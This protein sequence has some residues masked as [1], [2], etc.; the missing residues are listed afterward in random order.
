M[1][2][3]SY[4]RNSVVVIIGGTFSLK[5]ENSFD[6]VG[7]VVGKAGDLVVFDTG[8]YHGF[9][10]PLTPTLNSAPE[11]SGGI[12][13]TYTSNPPLSLIARPIELRHAL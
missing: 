11:G 4:G 7:P 8:L 12:L 6:G 10:P 9:C 1:K 2:T 3:E 13:R 5:T